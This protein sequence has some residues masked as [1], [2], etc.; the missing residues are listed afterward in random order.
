MTH[1]REDVSHDRT[2][3]NVLLSCHRKVMRLCWPSL[4]SL[5]RPQILLLVHWII[6]R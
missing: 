2:T 1:K 5:Q 6:N 3:R 4:Q